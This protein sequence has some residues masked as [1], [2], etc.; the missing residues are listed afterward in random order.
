[1]K[2]VLI[3]N[4]PNL[5]LLG[6]REPTHY[7]NDTLPQIMD[8]AIEHGRSLGFRV[9]WA[10]NDIEGELVKMIGQARGE[11]DAI[12]INP[13]AYTHTSIALRDAIAAVELPCIEVHLSN[14]HRR[15]EFR[16]ISYTAAVCI[17][18]IIGFGGFGYCLALTALA[19][20]FSREGGR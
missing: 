3:L 4:G 8:K 19:E 6:T 20:R 9:D 14:V 11:Y 12:I 18:Q 5:S 16:H 7:G 1:M 2:K 13:A 15:E 10:Q 17:G